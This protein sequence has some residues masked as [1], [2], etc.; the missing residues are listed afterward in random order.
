MKYLKLDVK[1]RKI[2]PHSLDY[3]PNTPVVEFYKSKFG[4]PVFLKETTTATNTPME[5]GK[6]KE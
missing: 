4:H 2:V 6:T 1:S 5:H 3:D